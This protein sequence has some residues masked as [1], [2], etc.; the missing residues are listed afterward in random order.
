MI[1]RSA[2]ESAFWLKMDYLL[3]HVGDPL[4][5]NEGQMSPSFFDSFQFQGGGGNLFED[6]L[7]ND[8]GWSIVSHRVACLF[9]QCS[10]SEDIKLVKLPE[11]VCQIHSK[12]AEYSVLGIKRKIACLDLVNSDLRWGKFPREHISAIYRGVLKEPMI[13]ENVDIFH[14]AEYPV[15]PVVSSRLAKAIADLCPKGLVFEEMTAIPSKS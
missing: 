7:A 8:L 11:R 13:P 2:S 4:S 1:N 9:A 14:V 3:S 15:M 10:N 5:I 6:M 12:L